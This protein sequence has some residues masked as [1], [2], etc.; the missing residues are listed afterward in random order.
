MQGGEDP[1]FTDEVV[2]GIVRRVKLR[3]PDCAVTLSLG[4]RSRESYQRLFDAGADRYLLRHETADEAH[5]RSLHPPE[6]SFERRMRCLSDLEIG[7]Q[8]GCG[9]MVGSP[10]GRPRRRS[11]RT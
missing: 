6:M 11:Q 7:Y 10:G 5:Y 3:H 1:F 4:E 9:F 8:T 2:C